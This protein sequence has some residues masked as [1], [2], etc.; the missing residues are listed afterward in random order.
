MIYRIFYSYKSKFLLATL[1]QLQ[2]KKDSS[3]SFQFFRRLNSMDCRNFMVKPIS[4][5]FRGADTFKNWLSEFI[6]NKDKVH[7]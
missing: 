3:I 1:L 5:R 2:D 4:K 7:N 6:K